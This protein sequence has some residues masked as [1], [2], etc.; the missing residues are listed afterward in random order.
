MGYLE[1][2]YVA[3]KNAVDTTL[4]VV[5]A[6]TSEETKVAGKIRAYYGNNFDYGSSPTEKDLYGA[7]LYETKPSDFVKPGEINLTQ[8]VLAVPA[9]FSLVIDANLHDF[10][11]GDIILS[12]VYKFLMPTESGI[13]VGFIKGNDCSL[14]LI[15]DWKLAPDMLSVLLRIYRIH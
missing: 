13:K 15:V 1:L 3:L 6:A 11:S 8:S 10:T 7:M 9:Q 12:R 2:Y 5:F 14:K 4:K